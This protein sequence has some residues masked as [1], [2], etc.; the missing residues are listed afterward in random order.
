MS[1]RRKTSAAKATALEV[2]LDFVSSPLI[3]S[4]QALLSCAIAGL[5][6]SC[7][8]CTACALHADCQQPI[9]GD[10]G[11]FAH[12]LKYLVIGEAPGAE[13]D[14][15]DKPFVGPSGKMLR[16]LLTTADI[17]NSC[18]IT[19]SVRCRPTG[20]RTPEPAEVEACSFWTRCLIQTIKP[21]LIITVGAV[22]AAYLLYLPQQ[23]LKIT[24]LCNAAQ[25]SPVVAAPVFPL[26]H[27]AAA[28]RKADYMQLWQLGL[29]KLITHLRGYDN[30]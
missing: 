16:E 23:Q 15:A 21:R 29:I 1:S 19:N 27:P 24:K 12:N 28:M 14:Q 10:H 11:Q 20:N 22:P 26:I 4:E 17:L 7:H 5:E 9:M 8:T 13:E 18:Y 3:S 2:E 25:N 6:Y 30:A